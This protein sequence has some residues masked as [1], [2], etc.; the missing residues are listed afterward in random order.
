MAREKKWSSIAPRLLTADG[1]SA[2]LV[3]VADAIDY[4]VKQVVFL[5]GT[6][7]PNKQV[8]INSIPSQTE[9]IVGELG[10][11]IDAFTDVSAY[12]TAAASTISSE[13]QIRPAIPAKEYERA[14]FEEEPVVAKRVVQVDPYGD[15][16]SENNP[17][18]VE[19]NLSVTESVI[20]TTGQITKI[21]ITT[22]AW[23][24]LERSASTDPIGLGPL[25]NRRVM[26]IQNLTGQ[27]IIIQFD[28]TITDTTISVTI[29]DGVEKTYDF[30]PNIK[31]Y[32]RSTTSTVDIVYEEGA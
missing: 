4:H 20:D 8:Q 2:G 28:N 6:A 16:Y 32:A 17:I 23:T 5:K 31:F 19:G 24:L 25:T 12:T 1:T 30:G 29:P 21:E 11:K 15:L 7:L 9:I 22:V 10:S 18:P 27:D 14:S 13:L 3:P 26:T